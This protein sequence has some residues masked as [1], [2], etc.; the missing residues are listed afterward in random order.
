MVDDPANPTR[1]IIYYGIYGNE[2]ATIMG[3]DI[4]YAA[5]EV[6]LG[7]SDGP[8]WILTDMWSYDSFG[9]DM[10]ID[11]PENDNIYN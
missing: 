5:R 1:S 3:Y 11:Y 7:N 6:L 4:Y 2:Q 9:F 8:Y 10:L